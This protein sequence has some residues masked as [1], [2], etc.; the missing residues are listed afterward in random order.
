MSFARIIT[1]LKM[2]NEKD[3]LI[4]LDRLHG[5][6]VELVVLS[7]TELGG[8]SEL[9]GYASLRSKGITCISA[10]SSD[11][12]IEMKKRFRGRVT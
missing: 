7:S 12:F 5:M 1:G 8:E 4:V 9:I 10:I 3:A 2:N 6:G 11:L